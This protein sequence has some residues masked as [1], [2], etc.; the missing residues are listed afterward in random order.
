[1]RDVV[2]LALLRK[3]GLGRIG[4]EAQV[5]VLEVDPNQH[6]MNQKNQN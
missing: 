1:V 5:E 3:N 6:V 4:D 2:S